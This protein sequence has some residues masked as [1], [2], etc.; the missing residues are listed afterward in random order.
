MFRWGGGGGTGK[1]A[2]LEFFGNFFVKFLTLGSG[3]FEKISTPGDT[4][5][6]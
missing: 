6:V 1:G 3:K 5:T 4:K 2:A